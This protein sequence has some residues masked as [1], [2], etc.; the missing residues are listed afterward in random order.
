M[1]QALRAHE[2][3]DVVLHAHDVIAAERLEIHVR[4]LASD[5]GHL[6]L[7]AFT[8]LEVVQRERRAHHEVT[9]PGVN[10]LTGAPVRIWDHAHLQRR[11]VQALI[12]RGQPPVDPPRARLS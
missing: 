4:D 11:H 12:V 7:A 5:L 2:H 6:G 10:D 1:D 9:G 8:R 3:A